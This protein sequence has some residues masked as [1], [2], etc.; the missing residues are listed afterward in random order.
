MVDVRGTHKAPIGRVLAWLDEQREAL[1][2]VL[3][4]MHGRVATRITL[5]VRLPISN[6]LARGDQA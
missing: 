2:A 1:R 4:E 5:T 3:A 6:H